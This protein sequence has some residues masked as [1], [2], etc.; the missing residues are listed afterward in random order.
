MLGKEINHSSPMTEA[1]SRRKAHKFLKIQ[2][3]LET[4]GNFDIAEGG[5]RAPKTAPSEYVYINGTA[6]LLNHF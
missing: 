1:G 6:D 4:G 5:E 3:R 2:F